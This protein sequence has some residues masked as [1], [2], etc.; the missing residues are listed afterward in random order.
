MSITYFEFVS[1]ALIIQQ[2]MRMSLIILSSVACL[3][4]PYFSTLSYTARFS[5]KKKSLNIK[6]VF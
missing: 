4:V 3:P 5:K 2:A 1:V 6:C